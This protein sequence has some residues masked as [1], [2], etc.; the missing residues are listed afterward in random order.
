M[1]AAV[2]AAKPIDQNVHGS[3]GHDGH[4]HHEIHPGHE[5]LHV[6]LLFVLIIFMIAAQMLLHQWKKRYYSSFRNITLV[7]LWLIPFVSSIVFVFWRMLIIWT[8]FTGLTLSI[9]WQASKQPLKQETPRSV[10]AWFYRIYKVC[11]A[12][13][14]FGYLLIMMDFFGVSALIG[15]VINSQLSFAA[16]GI[17]LVFY[18]IYYGVLGRD[19]AEVCS[20]RMASVMGYYTKGGI[21]TKTLH[22][23]ICAICGGQLKNIRRDADEIE[24]ETFKLNCGHEFHEFCIRGWTI[25]GKKDT[26][27]YCHERV[28]LRATFKNPWETQSILWVHLL[29]ALRYLIVWNPIIIVC[30]N[31]FLYYFDNPTSINP[32][33]T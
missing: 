25:V 3:V 19:C 27:P 7:G 2:E 13:A 33:T 8:L 4:K 5:N 29:D 21:P 16:T 1:D 32:S 23:N 30:I 15:S 26:C 12:T 10:Y 28:N 22:A 17:L 9:V 11:Y 6:I 14:V 20:D 18:G 24:E 31:L